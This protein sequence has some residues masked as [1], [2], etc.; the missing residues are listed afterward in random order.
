MEYKHEETHREETGKERT[1]AM[2]SEPN[3]EEM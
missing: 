2:V 1:Q 3:V